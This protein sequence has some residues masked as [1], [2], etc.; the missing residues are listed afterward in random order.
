LALRSLGEDPELAKVSTVTRATLSA[1]RDLTR[2][3]SFALV[4]SSASGS[5]VR[6]VLHTR[7]AEYYVRDDGI[8]VQSVITP[9]TFSLEDA[10][11]NTRLFEQ[12]AEG[13]A[14]RLLIDMSV[15]QS[16][17]PGVREYQISEDGSRWIAALA[18]VT[19]SLAARLSGNWALKFNRRQ[20][21][22]RMFGSIDA[23]VVW[24]LRQ[25]ADH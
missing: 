14:R 3:G 15:P 4:S 18:M 19:P 6:P 22:C 24:L 7:T 21:P 23:A 12:L 20:Y 1:P 17:E 5:G 25:P 11:A 8:V 16:P 9:G 13:I 10:K 2:S